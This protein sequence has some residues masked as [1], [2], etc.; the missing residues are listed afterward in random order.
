MN[1]NR[2]NFLGLSVLAATGFAAMPMLARADGTGDAPMDLYT[3]IKTRR[4]VRAYTDRQIADSDL[5]KILEAAMLAPSAANE[6][7]WE[8]V[9]I[10]D[11]K[12]LDKVTGIN[13]YASFAK[14]A[15]VCILVCLNEGKEKIR[16]MGI[17]DVS[18][19]AQNLM[20]AAR[21]LGI[22]TVFTGIYPD[23]DRIEKFQKLAGLP[24]NVIPIG[25]IVMGYPE[26]PGNHMVD[27]YNKDAIHHDKW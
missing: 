2:R 22:G 25:L 16:G 7:P 13:Q 15:P 8:F 17:I 14:K 9:I 6:Q 5:Q 19:C 10:R 3:A 11:K 26:I 27:R 4:S 23:K 12:I 18:M 1:G 21:G 20:L 24:A